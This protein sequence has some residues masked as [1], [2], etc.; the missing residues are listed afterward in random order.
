MT[1]ATNPR[2]WLCLCALTL[3]SAPLAAQDVP[4][5][6]ADKPADKQTADK[7]AATE[8]A[9]ELLQLERELLAVMDELVSAR[10]R[11]G[12][13][14]RT[15]FHTELEVEVIRRA[16]AQDLT[17][18]TLRLD[19]VTVHESD[20]SALA[21]DRAQ[22]FRG[23]VTPGKHELAVELVEAGKDDARYGYTRSERYRIEVKKDRRTHVELVL[24]DDSDMAE[25]AAE[26]DEGEYQ[27]D[28]TVRVT[29]SRAKD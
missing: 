2:V 15:L 27:L 19:G 16:D 17:R 8:R 20:G 5:E 3:T 23:F 10:A 11:A 4:A 26:G 29:S 14:A 22:L 7:T 6:S 1:R 13:L 21:H 12:V 24:R 18:V 28:S 25:E 9:A